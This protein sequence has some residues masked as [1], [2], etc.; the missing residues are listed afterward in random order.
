M[1]PSTFFNQLDTSSTQV[2]SSTTHPN[3]ADAKIKGMIGKLQT[4]IEV[5]IAAKANSPQRDQSAINDEMTQVKTMLEG[6]VQH[7]EA[8]LGKSRTLPPDFGI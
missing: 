7:L 5:E 3:A 2:S 8:E 4:R 1:D 6:K